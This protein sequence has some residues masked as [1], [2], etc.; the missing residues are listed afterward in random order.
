M[1]KCKESPI[2]D[3]R[4]RWVNGRNNFCWPRMGHGT[5]KFCP[6][7]TSLSPMD[8]S[9][10]WICLRHR[11]HSALA[12]L[13]RPSLYIDSKSNFKQLLPCHLFSYDE[14]TKWPTSVKFH[15]S[16]PSLGVQASLP[17]KGRVVWT[18][19]S[20]VKIPI[21]GPARSVMGPRFWLSYRG[22]GRFR[23]KYLR[24]R[25]WGRRVSRL[26]GNSRKRD[27]YVLWNLVD[28]ILPSPTDSKKNPSCRFF[29]APH[30]FR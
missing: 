21:N 20:I 4:R 7:P 24:F 27:L 25:P 3:T 10:R 1:N 13:G 28:E 19:T 2:S 22:C 23:K 26:S 14:I 15:Y 8:D 6:T 30:C 16:L 12:F 5:V 18:T 11:G 17:T 29:T 9:P